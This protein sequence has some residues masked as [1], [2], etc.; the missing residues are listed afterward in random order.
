MRSGLLHSSGRSPEPRVIRLTSCT[1]QLCFYS[2]A[3][4][5][6]SDNCHHYESIRRQSRGFSRVQSKAAPHSFR[7][8]RVLLP[9][10]RSLRFPVLKALPCFHFG[11]VCHM[12]LCVLPVRRLQA[13]RRCDSFAEPC[14]RHGAFLSNLRQG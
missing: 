9:L 2:S 11:N 1:L 13:G 6:L 14:I 10:K 12:F 3:T 8:C 7:V 5:T 4:A